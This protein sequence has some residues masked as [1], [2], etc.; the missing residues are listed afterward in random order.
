MKFGTSYAGS[1]SSADDLFG[2]V[3][4]DNIAE[5][6]AGGAS[7]YAFWKTLGLVAGAA[8]GFI[9]A[10]IPG[11]LIGATAGGAVGSV[12]DRTGK[13]AL[14]SFKELPQGEKMRILTSLA[15]KLYGSSFSFEK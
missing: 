15:A 9:V 4:E 8:L 10:N 11:A 5:E 13:P 12:R 1:S 14:E 6:M 7:R 2:S 3:F